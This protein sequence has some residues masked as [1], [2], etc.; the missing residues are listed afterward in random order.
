MVLRLRKARP[1]GE[2]LQERRGEQPEESKATPATRIIQHREGDQGR[3]SPTIHLCRTQDRRTRGKRCQTRGGPLTCT[4]AAVPRAASAKA[5]GLLAADGN[6]RL[7]PGSA[8]SSRTCPRDPSS[9]G[10]HPGTR[11]TPWKG[12]GEEGP[13]KMRFGPGGQEGPSAEL[14]PMTS[15]R[16]GRDPQCPP[17]AP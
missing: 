8:G 16:A 1:A 7:K 10:T 9:L 14:P 2:I 15:S 4:A 12:G 6:N 13:G 11:W 3:R 17:K 5:G